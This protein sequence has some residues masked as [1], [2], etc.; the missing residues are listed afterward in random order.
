MSIKI[1]LVTDYLGGGVDRAT[2]SFKQLE[3]AGQKAQFALRKAAIPATLALGALAKGAKSALAAG[4][5]VNSA[6][7]RIGQINK[8]MGLFGKQTDVVTKRLVKLAE[9]QGR[10]LGISNLTIKATQA[11]L[12]TFKNLAKSADVVGGAFDRANKAALDMAAAG[13][14]EATSNA[15]QLGKAL[16]DPIK[17][18]TALAKSGVTFT[19]Q[20]K[21][22][23]KTLVESGKVLEAQNMILEAIE[24]QVGN[25]ANATADDTAKISESFAQVGQA[26][27]LNMLPI[28]EQVTPK[29]LEL[30]DWARENPDNFINIAKAI[31]AI[32]ASVLALNAAMKVSLF[33]KATGAFGPLG[34]LVAAFAAAY[35]AIESYRVK[36]NAQYNSWVGMLEGVINAAVRTVNPII[37]VINKISPGNP[38]AKLAL[39]NI[40][41]LDTRLQS[42]KGLGFGALDQIPMMANGGIVK[43]SPG[44]TLAILGEGGRDEA[45]IPLD[46]AGGFGGGINITVHAGLLSSPDQVGQQIIEA[47]QK[48]QRRSGPVFAPA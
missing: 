17:G 48:A 37:D 6:N 29:L 11:K 33:F 35:A 23:I 22:K 28:L 42:Q 12:L 14:G 32:A 15:V 13:F 47:I 24:K 40:P 4:E 41:K 39:V 26:I 3:T 9:A 25:T 2:K 19:E 34:V 18:I 36:V 31:G 30:A 10:E 21:E 46:R 38:F 7:A 5:A 45:V 44:G 1:N 43:A 27:G 8:S 20:E 16:E